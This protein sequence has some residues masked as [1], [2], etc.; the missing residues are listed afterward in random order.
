[1]TFKTFTT[2]SELLDLLMMRYNLPKPKNPSKEQQKLFTQEKEIPIHFRV[3]NVL[4]LWTDRYPGD[5]KDDTVLVQRVLDFVSKTIDITPMLAKAGNAIINT[6]EKLDGKNLHENSSYF[7]IGGKAEK[8]NSIDWNPISWNLLEFNVKEL[9]EQIY[10]NTYCIFK[11]LEGRETLHPEWRNHSTGKYQAPRLYLMYRNT[12]A[13]FRWIKAEIFLASD[14]RVRV[15]TTGF[16]LELAQAFL[17]LGD[18]HD[19]FVILKVME[20]LTQKEFELVWDWL[21]LE[22][23][24]IWKE[25]KDTNPRA[26]FKEGN[27]KQIADYTGQIPYYE[28]ELVQFY[29]INRHISDISPEGLI[30]FEKRYSIY[31]VFSFLATAQEYCSEPP[32]ITSNETIIDFLTH[33]PILSDEQLQYAY[34]HINNAPPSGISPAEQQRQRLEAKNEAMVQS[35]LTSAVQSM[36]SNDKGFQYMLKDIIKEQVVNEIVSPIEQDLNN[37]VIRSELMMLITISQATSSEISNIRTLDNIVKLATSL[38]PTHLVSKKTESNNNGKDITFVV[39]ENDMEFILV[40]AMYSILQDDIE[41]YD[42]ILDVFTKDCIEP[43]LF[44]YTCE[45]DENVK[46]NA[47]K[48]GYRVEIL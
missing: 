40:D 37:F 6:L 17:K 44:L 13:L 11:A 27:E 4:K 2:T 8:N 30:N 32:K 16:F 7:E 12:D 47:I 5:F 31:Q 41:K 35:S 23:S 24:R 3:F 36:A 25:I 19:C 15:K 46:Q 45:I 21:D 34:E 29:D 26:T 14:I 9:A 10:R 48:N 43:S 18:Y 39:A 42:N 20:L 22:H 33:I 28:P 1:M 38:F